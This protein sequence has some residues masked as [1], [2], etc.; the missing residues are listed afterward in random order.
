MK[1][2]IIVNALI[3]ISKLCQVSR[4]SIYSKALQEQKVYLKEQIKFKDE[5]LK[6]KNDLLINEQKLRLQREN[7]KPLLKRLFGSKQPS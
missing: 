3:E 6:V 2:I 7:K 1:E 4:Q 5:Q